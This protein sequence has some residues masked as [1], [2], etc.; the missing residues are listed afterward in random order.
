VLNK[1]LKLCLVAP[2]GAGKST[3]A[4]YL[5]SRFRELGR[6]AAVY[7]L[8]E[9]LYELQSQIY[10]RAGRP[11]DHYRQDHRLLELIAT[12]MR[13]IN[14]RSILDD[15]LARIAAAPEQVLINDDLRD[16]ETDYRAL[17]QQGFVF[18][19]ISASIK[20]RHQRLNQR[21]DL[22]THV[23]SKLDRDLCAMD[24]DYL[25]V[26]E[27][28]NREAYEAALDLVV[29]RLCAPRVAEARR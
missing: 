27:T 5:V 18:I 3:A 28:F 21:H 22:V 11:I 25:I 16:Y 19:K 29:E 15:F 1:P 2:S 12:E 4:Q 17:R 10:V 6:S 24:P 20:A 13:R 14:P 26:N 23:E 7:K 9:P 8:A